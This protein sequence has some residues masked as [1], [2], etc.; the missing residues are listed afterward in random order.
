VGEVGRH[1]VTAIGGRGVGERERRLD[2]EKAASQQAS[3]R[4]KKT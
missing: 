3:E 2:S 1:E 4:K